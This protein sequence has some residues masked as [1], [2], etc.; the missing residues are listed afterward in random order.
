MHG[1]VRQVIHHD[2]SESRAL[3]RPK[4]DPELPRDGERPARQLELIVYTIVATT[5]PERLQPFLG[6]RGSDQEVGRLMPRAR[7]PHHNKLADIEFH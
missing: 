7:G 2:G 3:R 5:L 4:A 6:K 1:F